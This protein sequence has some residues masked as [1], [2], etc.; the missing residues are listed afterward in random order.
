[1]TAYLF[2]DD[3]EAAAQPARRLVDLYR[4]DPVNGALVR[5]NLAL[6]E[7]DREALLAVRDS[8][9]DIPVPEPLKERIDQIEAESGERIWPLHLPAV[10]LMLECFE[11][12]AAA[13]HRGDCEAARIPETAL[14]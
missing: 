2:A 8:L 14:P 11:D 6:I 5:A 3:E 9:A 10:N 1:M 7:R 4:G 12:G 13:M